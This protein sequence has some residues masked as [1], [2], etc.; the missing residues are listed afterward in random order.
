[1]WETV[2]RRSG[3]PVSDGDL[4]LTWTPNPILREAGVPRT[5][6]YTVEFQVAAPLGMAGFDTLASRRGLP[7]GRYRF[8]V[9]HPGYE[10]T[11]DPFEVVP[12]TLD[13][14]VEMSGSDANVT[15]SFENTAGYRLLDMD[16]ARSNGA[17]PL[18]NATLTAS[19]GDGRPDASLT[20]DANGVVTVPSAAGTTVTLTDEYQNHATISP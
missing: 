15:L 19:F 4:L 12:A 1:T 17:V 9:T 8:R 3:R 11:S 13:A 14:A 6:Y 16:G 10:L 20:T 5:H 18:R 7:E 2:T